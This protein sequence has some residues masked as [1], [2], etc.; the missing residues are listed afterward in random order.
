MV[1]GNGCIGETWEKYVKR[2]VSHP[3]DEIKLT[4]RHD[5]VI[6]LECDEMQIVIY[7][8][9]RGGRGLPFAIITLFKNLR[10]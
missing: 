10:H 6:V 2:I 8:C 3:C 7:S 5:L 4:C 1:E 9:E